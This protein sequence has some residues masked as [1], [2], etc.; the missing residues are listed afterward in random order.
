MMEKN[1]LHP[2]SFR[3][4]DPRPFPVFSLLVRVTE[5]STTAVVRQ[6]WLNDSVASGKDAQ[7]MGKWK[8]SQNMLNL[9]DLGLCWVI[10]KWVHGCGTLRWISCCQETG[11]VILLSILIIL[12]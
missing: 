11:V 1:L 7:T 10:L 2:Q 5:A 12:I 8:A 9:M 6:S 4:R 3:T